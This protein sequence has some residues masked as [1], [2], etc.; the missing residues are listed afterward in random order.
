MTTEINS[1][2]DRAD[3]LEQ[4][5]FKNADAILRNS[6]ALAR[7]L[8]GAESHHVAELECV[9][10]RSSNTI[11]NDGHYMN[12]VLWAEG[13]ERLRR[14]LSAMNYEHTI[15][16]NKN[17]LLPPDQVTLRWLFY[18]VPIGGWLAAGSLLVVV[19][20]LGFFLAKNDLITKVVNLVTNSPTP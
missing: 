2:I 4:F 19:F 17:S 11:Y 16:E 9:T 1:L 8:F 6:L 13:I 20:S 5:D 10:F 3:G 15:T 14:V 18:H 12:G 7:N